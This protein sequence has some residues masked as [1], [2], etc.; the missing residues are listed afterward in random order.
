MVEIQGFLAGWM[1]LNKLLGELRKKDVNIPNHIYSDFRSSKMLIEYLRTYENRDDI[2]TESA[3]DMRKEMEFTILRLRETMMVWAEEREGVKYR[4]SWEQQFY[5]AMHGANMQLETES[6]T[7]ISDL[8]REKDV[9]FFRIKLPDEIPVEIISE[10][11]EYCGVLISLDG[12][13]HLQVSGRRDC[14]QD[15]LKRIG[16]RFYGDSELNS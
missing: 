13:Y 5:E 11:A 2:D 10:I 14:V 9:S 15:A 12:D 7:P 6:E 16:D 4:K 1:V 8:P 3:V